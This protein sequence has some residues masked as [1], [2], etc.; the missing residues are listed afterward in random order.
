VNNL[1]LTGQPFFARLWKW[2]LERKLH[3]PQVAGYL[4]NMRNIWQ[5][6]ISADK[7]YG[8]MINQATAQVLLHGLM[9]YDY[10]PTGKAPVFVI[11]Y[12]GAGQMAVGAITYLKEWLQ[13]P[14]YVISLG[15][16][17]ASDPG[18]LAADHLYHLY[19][20]RDMAH[21]YSLSAPGR[22]RILPASAWNRARRQGKVSMVNMGPMGH[23]GSGGYL[24]VKSVL[25][26]GQS[27]LD[28]TVETMANI[29]RA[30]ISEFTPRVAAASMLSHLQSVEV[31]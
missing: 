22:W 9:R 18:V 5:V 30:R 24:D 29:V 20:S 4:I 31:K 25:P 17:F 28:N 12:S 15:G 10:D 2:S 6:M 7:R 14:A 11:G 26:N 23:T 1:A 3:G 27:Y 13:A 21:K 8:P 19:G 16:I